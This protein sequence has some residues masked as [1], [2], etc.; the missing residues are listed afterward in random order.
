MIGD[1]QRYK[2]EILRE[3]ARDECAKLALAAYNTAMELA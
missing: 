3:D 2:S 1:Y